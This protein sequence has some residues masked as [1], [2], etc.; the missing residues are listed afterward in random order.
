MDR[1]IYIC[2][3]TI[4]VLIA[5]FIILILVWKRKHMCDEGIIKC[6]KKELER[7]GFNVKCI[8]QTGGNSKQDFEMNAYRSIPIYHTIY[9]GAF[10]DIIEKELEENEAK[11]EE[12]KYIAEDEYHIDTLQ[13]VRLSPEYTNARPMNP[14]EYV[15]NQARPLMHLDVKHMRVNDYVWLDKTDGVR[16]MYKENDCIL[17]CERYD[18]KLYCF[19]ALVVNGVD[20]RNRSYEERMDAVKNAKLS[21]IIVKE[22]YPVESIEELITYIESNEKSPKTG[23]IIDG[24]ILQ[25]RKKAYNYAKVYKLKLPIMNTIDFRLK[26]VDG[27]NFVLY[28]GGKFIN[29]SALQFSY[30]NIENCSLFVAPYYANAHKFTVKELPEKNNYPSNIAAEI[31]EMTKTIM[32]NPVNF[33]GRIVELSWDGSNYY[34]MRIRTDKLYPNGYRT[35]ISNIGLVYAPITIENKYFEDDK[36]NPFSEETIGRFHENSHMVRKEIMNKLPELPKEVKRGSCIDLSCGRGGDLKALMDKGYRNLFCVDLDKIALTQLVN[37]LYEGDFYRHTWVNVFDYDLS[38][39]MDT[40]YNRITER[41]DYSPGHCF[42]LIFMNFAIHYVIENAPEINKLVRRLIKPGGYFAFTFFDGDKILSDN[43]LKEKV[44]GGQESINEYFQDMM[45]GGVRKKKNKKTKGGALHNIR[46]VHNKRKTTGNVDVEIDK[47]TG[48]Q[49]TDTVYVDEEGTGN[50]TEKDHSNNA[51][52]YGDFTIE[53]FKK[54]GE[55]WGKFPLPTI[56]AS[57]Y[58]EEPLV[59]R[60]KLKCFGED[61]TEYAD[62]SNDAYFGLLRLRV[63]KY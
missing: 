1:N 37:K 15:L 2:L 48:E 29:N 38:T 7:E 54:D 43:G 18:G 6:L 12:I 5:C 57:G 53:P 11:V 22:Y 26:H 9:G 33:D 56:A 51:Y 47:S 36:G 10:E 63:Y 17:D 50:A 60:E 19:D 13:D 49:E 46:G 40:L 39:E 59:L 32:E 30:P 23:Q 27:N 24:V 3:V 4:L 42:Q 21:D 55:W 45:E 62:L 8:C 35:A 44:T 61:F 20:V 41:K 14:D 31:K 16:E 58:R 34:P 28:S 25:E 52:S